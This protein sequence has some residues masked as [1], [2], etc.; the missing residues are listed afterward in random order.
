MNWRKKEQLC[1]TGLWS[2]QYKG[3]ATHSV[4]KSKEN[5]NEAIAQRPPLYLSKLFEGGDYWSLKNWRLHTGSFRK[6]L[7]LLLI[8]L[9]QKWIWIEASSGH[10][11]WDL[12]LKEKVLAII[13]N[14]FSCLP[15]LV[16]KKGKKGPF[17]CPHWQYSVRL[18]A[19]T[20]V[21]DI[22]NF[23][24]TMKMSLQH[25]NDCLELLILV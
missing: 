16:D 17:Y 11:S 7:C 4:F 3:R 13:S 9:K 14:Y 10:V 20:R 12:R 8:A 1:F 6:K 21:S 19:T 5:P 15:L 2:L 24:M 18:A 22:S 23:Q 25:D